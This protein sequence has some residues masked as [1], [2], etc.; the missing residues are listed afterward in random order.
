MRKT[1]LFLSAVIAS[2]RRRRPSPPGP[3][4]RNRASGAPGTAHR[5][6]LRPGRGSDLFAVDPAGLNLT[7]L[8]DG[9]GPVDVQPAWSPDGGRIAFL[10]RFPTGRL[11]LMVMGRAA[12]AASA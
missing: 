9:L 11:D 12:P 2:P 8:T 6:P 10:H 7:N 1:T 3:P 4:S 5:V